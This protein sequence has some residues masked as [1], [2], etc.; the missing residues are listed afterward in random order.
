V[1]IPD[2]YEEVRANLLPRIRCRSFIP[3]T[4][5]HLKIEG[6]TP[7]EVVTRPLGEDFSVELAVDSPNCSA[8][9]GKQMLS[10]WGITFDEA[11][12]VAKENMWKICNER[13]KSPAPGVYLS[14]WQDTYDAS[15]I[16][17]HDLIWQLE[18]EGDHV[19]VAPT[20]DVLMVTGSENAQGLDVIAKESLKLLIED[21]RPISGTMLRLDGSEWKPFMPLPDHPAHNSCNSLFM[22]WRQHEYGE[23][24]ELLEKL[25]EQDGTDIFVASFTVV[26]AKDTGRLQSYCVLPKNV[27]TLLPK[28]DL[29]M[30]SNSSDPAS[31][32]AGTIAW[33]ELVSVAG[34]LLVPDEQL[35][36]P[37]FRVTEYPTDA[38]LAKMEFCAP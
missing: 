17:M 31:G 11:L 20:R 8:T 14:S 3:I 32:P 30:L 37:R 19:A 2:D 35:F 33:D 6:K 29:V 7:V 38:Q 9:V 1:D 10:D 12:K 22:A 15:R 5:L 18:V 21:S 27:D 28:T 36:P 34:D 13:F 24:K 16:F 26:Q 4:A 23:Q 25:F